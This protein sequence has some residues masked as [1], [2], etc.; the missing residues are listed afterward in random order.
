L[1]DTILCLKANTGKLYHLGIGSPVAISTI[2]R[3]NESRSYKIYENLA[4]QLTSEA[5]D[6][7][8][9]EIESDVWLHGNVLAID[10]TTI[11]LSLSTLW[12]ATFRTTKGGKKLH[13][14]LDL[15]TAVPEFTLITPASVHDVRILDLPRFESNNFYIMD[16]GYV[17]YKR[18]FKIH[19]CVAYF[20]TRAKDNMSYRRL[21]SH[22]KEVDSGVIYDQSVKLR[23]YYASIDYHLKI[24]RIK[25]KDLESGKTLIFL[26]NNFHLKATEVAQLYKNRWKIELFFKCI[27]QHLKIKLFWGL[28]KM[29]L[30]HKF[31]LLSLCMYWLPLQ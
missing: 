14:Q 24:R 20:I 16:R 30:N 27:K 19:E 11:D 21:Y 25:Y 13:T 15:S 6:L 8:L 4:R 9:N 23:N 18:L 22:E 3:A 26:T 28:S 12:W 5:K 7:Y 29:Q 31:G 10:A 17:D 1:S 2:A